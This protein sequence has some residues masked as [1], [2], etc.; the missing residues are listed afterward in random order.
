MQQKNDQLGDALL[1]KAL[2][3]TTAEIVEEYA[4]NNEDGNMQL[5]K[6]K[7]TTKK[8]PPDIDAAKTLF[9]FLGTEQNKYSQLTDEQLEEEKNKL[10]EQL[11]NIKEKKDGSFEDKSQN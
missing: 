7:V 5:V 10:L 4:L 1:S 11:K 8:L 6:K 3:C 9:E 2:G